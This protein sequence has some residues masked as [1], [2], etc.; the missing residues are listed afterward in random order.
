[1]IDLCLEWISFLEKVKENSLC[2][3]FQNKS[4]TIAEEKVVPSEK[5]TPSE[6]VEKG[7]N[8]LNCMEETVNMIRRRDLDKFQGQSTT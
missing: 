6:E 3:H 7:T 1:M 5:V 8:I 2:R 4:S